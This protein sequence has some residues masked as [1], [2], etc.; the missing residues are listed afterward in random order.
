[1]GGSESK[2]SAVE[3]KTETNLSIVSVHWTSFGIGASSIILGIVCLGIVILL[4][5]YIKLRCIKWLSY[6][7]SYG[8]GSPNGYRSGG[9]IVQIPNNTIE[10]S[11]IPRTQVVQ[12]RPM[13][14]YQNPVI[15]DVTPNSNTSPAATTYQLQLGHLNQERI[16]ALANIGN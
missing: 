5:C 15:Q 12:N 1:M 7:P 8:F 14:T 10:M 16:N 9:Q 6:Q 13:I 4:G 2:E 11:Q 3:S